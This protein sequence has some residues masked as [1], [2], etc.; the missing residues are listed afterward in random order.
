MLQT[1]DGNGGEPWQI[2]IN[3]SISPTTLGGNKNSHVRMPVAFSSIQLLLGDKARLLSRRFS[4]TEHLSHLDQQM[5]NVL[6]SPVGFQ[7]CNQS[8]GTFVADT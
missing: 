7:P 8:F 4:P 2:S 1:T 6:E 5:M 3:Q